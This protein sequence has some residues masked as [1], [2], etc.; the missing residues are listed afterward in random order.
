MHRPA[1][2]HGAWYSR[3]YLGV[4]I[5]PSPIACLS[6]FFSLPAPSAQQ[7]KRKP[8]Y[9]RTRHTESMATP[10]TASLCSMCLLVFGLL[11]VL[12]RTRFWKNRY[13]YVFLWFL[14]K[15]SMTVLIKPLKALIH[16]CFDWDLKVKG[17]EEF[18]DMWHSHKHIADQSCI[19]SVDSC[20]CLCVNSCSEVKM[21]PYDG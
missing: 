10:L 6:P 17:E 14:V 7:P 12:N 19:Q 18:S 15:D 3:A 5:R 16:Q 20:I 13:V 1:G 21:S 9:P 2:W 11:L 8:D 4:N